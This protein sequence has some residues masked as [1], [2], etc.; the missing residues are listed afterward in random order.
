ML[1]LKRMDLSSYIFNYLKLEFD[2]EEDAKP[3]KSFSEFEG[4]V[5]FECVSKHQ[6]F[7]LMA[8]NAATYFMFNV[9]GKTV[10]N[11]IPK[12]QSIRYNQKMLFR[13]KP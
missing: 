3:I 7:F 9:R 13:L 6:C 12:Y 1:Q 5:S 8:Q 4:H 11:N 10:I 2:T